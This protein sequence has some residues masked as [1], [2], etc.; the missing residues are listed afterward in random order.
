M[1]S[2]WFRFKNGIET[3]GSSKSENGIFNFTSISHTLI[4]ETAVG[5][6]NYITEFIIFFQ[7]AVIRDS[8]DENLFSPDSIRETVKYDYFGFN[9]SAFDF[10]VQQ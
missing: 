8:Y 10:T 6:S 2:G 9:T 5:K 3:W 1:D 4:P 7:A